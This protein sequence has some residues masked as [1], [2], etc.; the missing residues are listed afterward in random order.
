MKSFIEGLPFS[1]EAGLQSLGESS[2]PISS[3][4]G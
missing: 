2:R 4:E 3:G 1:N